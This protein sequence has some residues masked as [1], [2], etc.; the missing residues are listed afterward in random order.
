M[1]DSPGSLGSAFKQKSLKILKLSEVSIGKYHTS[2]PMKVGFGASYNV[3]KV[4]AL[5]EPSNR[6]L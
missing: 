3:V 5:V 2:L 1:N 6:Y 4:S